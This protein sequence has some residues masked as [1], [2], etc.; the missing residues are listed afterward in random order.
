MSGELNAL[1]QRLY[2]QGYT[3]ENHPDTVCWGDWQNFSYKLETMLDFTWETPCGLLI[4]GDSDVGRDVAG[5]DCCY[6]HISFCPENDN[7]LLSCPYQR[8]DCAHVPA[9]FTL[10]MCPCHQTDRPY[11]Y[12]HSVEKAEAENAR[13]AHKQ[14]MELTGGSYCACVVS[15]NGYEGG[16]CEVKYDVEQCIQCGCKNDVWSAFSGQAKPLS[17]KYVVKALAA[18]AMIGTNLVL[19]PFPVSVAVDGFCRR[20]SRTRQ[21]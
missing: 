12:E 9:G 19:R 5:S 13:E 20:T 7:P 4:K 18:L 8:K 21:K 17:E 10:V 3:R 14:Y 1:T 6:Q 15:S 11:D 16:W 2:A